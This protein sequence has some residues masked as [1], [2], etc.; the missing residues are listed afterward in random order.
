[1]FCPSC[2]QEKVSPDTKFCS[3]CGFLLSG[4]SELLQTGGA[5]P[6]RP[7]KCSPRTRAIKQAVF[8]FFLAIV[9]PV[10]IA[11]IVPAL[12]YGDYLIPL[13]IGP[14]V[15]LGYNGLL[16]LRYAL[17]LKDPSPVAG[18]D[19]FLTAGQTHMDR[20]AS[21]GVLPPQQTYPA[22]QFSM[23]VGSNRHE[24]SD[25]EPRSV[26]EGTTKLLEKDEPL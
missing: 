16:R 23:P 19:D 4:A 24:T 12:G 9:I 1:M 6:E 8:L 5:I 11:L 7:K 26:T 17:N 3:R 20:P 22:G 14:A 2:G 10:L 15:I 13:V 25:L 18:K 21:L